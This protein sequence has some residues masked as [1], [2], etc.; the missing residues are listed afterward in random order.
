[1]RLQKDVKSA[2]DNIYNTSNDQEKLQISYDAFDTAAK[3]FSHVM[4]RSGELICNKTQD[5]IVQIIN[6][7]LTEIIF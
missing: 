5:Y 7:M 6:I 3:G 2:C 1:M 4:K